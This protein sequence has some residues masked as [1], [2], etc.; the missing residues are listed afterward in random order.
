[1]TAIGLGAATLVGL[2]AFDARAIVI[3]DD[4]A[5]TEYLVDDADYPALVDLFGPG[6]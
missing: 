5:D 2:T 6:D 3:R 4:V 1:M